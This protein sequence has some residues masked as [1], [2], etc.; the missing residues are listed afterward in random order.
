MTGH[1]S[2]TFIGH[3]P[4]C[5]PNGIQ[6]W[7]TRPNERVQKWNANHWVGAINF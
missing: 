2:A 7:V 1:L 5:A 3:T 4:L 6:L